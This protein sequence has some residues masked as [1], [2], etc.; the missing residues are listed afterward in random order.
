MNG[1]AGQTA[2]APTEA[3]IHCCIE[4]VS[5]RAPYTELIRQQDSDWHI[6]EL[7]AAF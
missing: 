1:G 7:S 3:L 5:Y 2:F 4:T 6:G